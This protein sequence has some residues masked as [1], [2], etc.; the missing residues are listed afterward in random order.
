MSI[1]SVSISMIVFTATVLA[2]I[3]IKLERKTACWDLTGSSV[4]RS[5]C[6]RMTNARIEPSSIL[7]FGRMFTLTWSQCKIF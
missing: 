6:K 5:Q 3:Y 1:V 2:H 4:T 7:A